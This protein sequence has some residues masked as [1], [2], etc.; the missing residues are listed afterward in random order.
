M[1]QIVYNPGPEPA[2]VSVLGHV[3]GAREWGVIDS[4]DEVAQ[5]ALSSR[6]VYPVRE[7]DARNSER[8]ELRAVVERF[9]AMSAGE[10]QD[11]PPAGN[12]DEILA[13][14]GGDADRARLALEAEEAQS[15]PRV[16]LLEELREIAGGDSP[17]PGEGEG[18]LSSPQNDD[19]TEG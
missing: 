19:S 11:Y 9:D 17:P 5:R 16:T 7:R 4:G 10:A 13:W 1:P 8:P 6:R 14:V 12:I 3:I 15:K 18:P 2:R